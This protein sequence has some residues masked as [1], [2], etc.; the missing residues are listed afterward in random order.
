MR[1]MVKHI[2]RICEYKGERVGIR[3]ARKHAAWYIRGV[4]GAAS[5]RQRV[6]ALSSI[7]ELEE[8]AFKIS[9]ENS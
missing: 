7:E 6:G 9:A 3:E 5:Y 4:R 1:V 2:R 8:L